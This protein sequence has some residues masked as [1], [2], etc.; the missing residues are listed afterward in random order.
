MLIE[1]VF[2]SYK[3][4]NAHWWLWGWRWWHLLAIFK[5]DIRP[6]LKNA[7]QNFFSLSSDHQLIITCLTETKSWS[8]LPPPLD[9]HHSAQLVLLSRIMMMVVMMVM[10][11]K[12]HVGEDE[13]S[14]DDGGSRAWGW[15][16]HVAIN[17]LATVQQWHLGRDWKDTKD[18]FLLS[19]KGAKMSPVKYFVS[20]PRELRVKTHLQSSMSLSMCLLWLVWHI[21]WRFLQITTKICQDIKI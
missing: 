3:M 12:R 11:P 14:S 6:I 1:D 9:R 20:H 16:V 19:L 17:V 2:I 10:S 15:G 5:V 8:Q 13:K 18:F 21:T 4:F 7:V